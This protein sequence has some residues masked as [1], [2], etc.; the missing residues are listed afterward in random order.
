M[1]NAKFIVLG[2]L[3]LVLAIATTL[4]RPTPSELA[5]A[6]AAIADSPGFWDRLSTEMK[7]RTKESLEDAPKRRTQAEYDELVEKEIARKRFWFKVVANRERVFFP[8]GMLVGLLGVGLIVIGLAR[9]AAR[10]AANPI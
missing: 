8:V 3:L 6:D 7:L 2:A 9:P 10:H 5:D 1:T 4:A